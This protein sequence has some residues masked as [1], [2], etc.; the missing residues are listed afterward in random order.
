MSEIEPLQNAIDMLEAQRSVLGDAVVDAALAPL[1]ARM[2]A[3][4]AGIPA[5]HLREPSGTQPDSAQSED[6]VIEERRL[7]SV[8]FADLVDFTPMTERTDPEDM[9]EV[10]RMYFDRWTSAIQMYGGVV[11]KFIGDAVM[12]VFG[13]HAAREDDAERAV[14]AALEMRSELEALNQRIEDRFGLRLSMRS[15]VHTGPVV[16]SLHPNRGDQNFT[17]VGDTVNLAS[18]LQTAAPPGGILVSHE[19]FRLARGAFTF[20][21]LEPAKVKGKRDPVRIYLVQG[22]KPRALRFERTRVESPLV[23]REAEIQLLMEQIQQVIATGRQHTLLIEGEAGIGKSRLLDEMEYRFE[24]LPEVLRYFKGRASPYLQQQPYALLRDVFSYRFSIQDGD[25]PVTA[26]EKLA[27]GLGSDSAARV[28]AQLLG[29]SGHDGPNGRA[30]PAPRQ[31]FSQALVELTGFFRHAA[32]AAP[33]VIALE[34]MQWADS[35]TS[36]MIAALRRELVDLPVLWVATA[37][38]DGN[39]GFLPEARALGEAAPVEDAGGPVRKVVLKPL[40][41]EEAIVLLESLL[42]QAHPDPEAG[43]GTVPEAL[44]RIAVRSAEGNPFYLEELLRMLIEDGLVAPTPAGWQAAEDRLAGVSI[45]PTLAEFLQARLDALP[46]DER[47][48]L[49]RAAVV[50]RIFWDQALDYLNAGA[51]S[52]IPGPEEPCSQR[53]RSAL[54]R[55]RENDVILRRSPSQFDGTHEYAFRQNLLRDATYESLLRRQR[56]AY[57]AHAARWLEEITSRA[58]RSGEYAALIAEH[59]ALA[60]EPAPAAEWYARAGE[61]ASA[62]YANAEAVHALSRALDLLGED[63]PRTRYRLLMEREKVYDRM[64]NRTAQTA[65]LD[66]LEELARNLGEPEK[67]VEVALRRAA[68]AFYLTR[69]DEAIEI[70]TRALA[71]AEQA[72]SARLTGEC[73]LEIGRSL[74]W[75]SENQAAIPHLERALDVARQNGLGTVEAFSVWNLGVIASNMGEYALADERLAAARELFASLGDREG[76]ALSTA[77][78]GNTAF[79]LG[80]LETAG[81]HWETAR[82]IFH[83]TG[84]RLREATLANNLAALAY[85]LG[86]YGKALHLQNDALRIYHEAGD[87]N[88]VSVTL[89]NQGE[90]LREE[91]LYEQAR[92]TFD[93]AL[94]ITQNIGDRFMSTALWA[95]YC[96]LYLL[97]GS[98]QKALEM[99]ELALK[100]SREIQAPYYEGYSLLRLGRVHLALGDLEQAE[101]H[102]EQA[103]E[104]QQS[105]GQTINALESRAMLG[106]VA[107]ERGDARGALHLVEPL[108]SA[109]QELDISGADVPVEAYLTM[110]RVLR[111]NHD[112][113]AVRVIHAAQSWLMAR[114]GKIRKESVRRSFLENVAANRVLLEMHAEET[115]L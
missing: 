114:A 102:F 113:R 60:E 14:R 29:F 4:T 76:E 62:R 23:G 48:L 111:A 59:Y 93:K 41:G 38:P 63:D 18:R 74:F 97:T 21:A 96:R 100:T 11:E 109:L 47:A 8:L 81:V 84:Q 22:A 110:I 103:A 85:N 68:L 78:M 51:Q 108:L 50:G 39:G 32:G 30:Q 86:D 99:G 43:A 101:R 37:R 5:E 10:L 91:G 54:E 58:S 98:P 45:P 2:Q 94:E 66:A 71:Q 12:A 6:A 112:P 80:N 52:P 25:D 40:S 83:W 35:S 95:D 49:Q 75:K 27:G 36:E 42:A 65:D 17:V 7:V 104:V 73:E 105:I 87:R 28:V 9:R 33:V 44:H 82:E 69:F 67:Q 57:H 46:P 64:I 88:G 15:A 107:L 56:R 77:Q 1:L 24:L 89:T 70:T 53:T 115:A 106:L 13:L 61:L 16:A 20:Q 72:G 19:T 34:D 92:E 90:L 55:L 3:L 31:L 79:N 26:L